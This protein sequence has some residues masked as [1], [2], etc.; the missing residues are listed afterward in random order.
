MPTPK[1]KPS[2]FMGLRQRNGRSTRNRRFSEH[3]SNK[4]LNLAAGW[5]QEL[6]FKITH[7]NCNWELNKNFFC[8]QEL[9]ASI[10]E[11]FNPLQ[12]FRKNLV[13]NLLS[14]K[15]ALYSSQLCAALNVLVQL[16]QE[17]HQLNAP[18]YVR[19]T[20]NYPIILHI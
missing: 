2:R 1:T 16:V 10:L 6:I 8:L 7:I 13:S 12:R 17:Q 18:I 9:G 20:Y 14:E 19:N 11:V 4:Q 15:V 5:L 3:Q